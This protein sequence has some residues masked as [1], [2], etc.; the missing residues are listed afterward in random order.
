[1]VQVIAL[2]A[3]LLAVPLTVEYLRQGEIRRQW[4]TSRAQLQESLSTAEA[5]N[6][7]LAT[8]K[9]YVQSDAYVE[10]AARSELKMA[11]P[12]DVVVVVV[13]TEP[14]PEANQLGKPT[15]TATPAPW[16]RAVFGGR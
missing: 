16:W 6:R 11:R 5:L 4:E 13:G 12:G 10:E 2:A 7:E 9:A 3:L 15:G 8:R 1:M 14:A